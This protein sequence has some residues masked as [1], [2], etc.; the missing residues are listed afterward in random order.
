M[1]LYLWFIYNLY[2]YY[3]GIVIRDRPPKGLIAH[4]LLTLLYRDLLLLL[5]L[6]YESLIFMFNVEFDVVVKSKTV[7]LALPLHS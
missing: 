5:L 4:L 3:V 7:D 6:Q 2:F 1:Y